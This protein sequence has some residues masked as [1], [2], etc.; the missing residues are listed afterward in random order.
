M[1]DYPESQVSE[2]LEV[3][4]ATVPPKVVSGIYLFGSATDEGLKPDSDVDLL[5][6]TSRRLTVEEKR[7]LVSGILPLSGGEERRALELTVVAHDDVRP[8]RYPP[9]I[10]LQFGEWRRAEFESGEG[11]APFTSPDLTITLASVLDSGHCL[12]GPLPSDLL[13]PI[14]TQDLRRAMTDEV[15][16]LLDDLAN[17]TRNVLLT[18]ARICATL[19]TGR[20]LSK[21][22]AASLVIES[23]PMEARAP[24]VEARDLYLSGGWGTWEDRRAVER[25]VNAMTLRI[26][27]LTIEHP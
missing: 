12:Q 14:P 23:L 25:A 9:T 20:I 11:I 4:R 27:D 10:D 8:W 2:A 19:E 26:R 5:I 13:D 22:E 18:L 1:V 6:I 15:P 21:G 16:G 24:V 7:G 17:D 3:F